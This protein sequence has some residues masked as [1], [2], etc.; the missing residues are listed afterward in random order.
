MGIV[1][2]SEIDAQDY[3]AVFY[4]GGHGL[5]WDLTQNTSSINLI[6]TMFEEG[7]PVAAICHG[8]CV[9]MHTKDKNGLPLVNSKKVT[10]FTNKEEDAVELT[11]VVPFLVE[12][13]LRENGGL[14][15]YAD[16]FCENVAIDGNLI[17]GQN[18]ASSVGI[19]QA[20]LSLL[21]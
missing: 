16:N 4:P 3:D 1:K 7:K 5:L 17:T 13:S 20:V 11:N 12:D 2:L 15:T 19:A 14:F 18:P 9:F 10:C 6:E 21:T 8:P